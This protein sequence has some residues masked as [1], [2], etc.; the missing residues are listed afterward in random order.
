VD[1]IPANTY[2]GVAAV[3]TLAV[4]AQWVTSDKADPALVYEIVKALYSEAGQKALAAGHAKGQ[5]IT[6]QNAVQGAG[7][8]LHPGAERFYRERGLLK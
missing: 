6:A 4:G 2:K 3:K 1:E 5:Y 8:P 7:I